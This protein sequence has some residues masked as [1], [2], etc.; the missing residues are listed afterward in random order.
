MKKFSLHYITYQTFP[1]STANSLQTI[2]NIKYLL[3]NNIEVS[4]FFPLRDSNSNS[5]IDSINE[6]YNTDLNFEITGLKHNYPF[7]KT[8]YLE[9]ILFHA[10]HFLWAKKNVKYILKNFQES[11][12]YMTR[13]DW[14][15]FF[16]IL[17]RKKVVFECHQTSKLRTII[18]FFLK[19]KSNAKIVF[20]NPYLYEKYGKNLKRRNC[21]ILQNGV[22]LDEIDSKLKYKK[23]QIIFAGNIERFKSSRGID[24]LINAFL[25]SKI[26]AEYKLIIVG[27]PDSAVEK[28][29]EEYINSETLK[30]LEILGYLNHKKTLKILAESQI[31]VLI[32]TS[33]NLHSKFYTSPLKYFEYLA[34]KLK[35]I[36]VDLPSHRVLKY[37]EEI[38]YFNEG[39]EDQLISILNNIDKLKENN[40]TNLNEITL[41]FR[42]KE[43]IKFI[44]N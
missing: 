2:K 20:L 41:D 16:L 23:K 40:I 42:I 21:I 3:R 38:K 22:D 33:N 25:K 24:L 35:I 17:K 32:N 12:Y 11:N 37:N 30:K 27:G 34:F 39:D 26:N 4:L 6:F 44:E 5:S 9:K 43:L 31:G 28:L 7:G 10:S 18:L 8:K 36:A 14:V 1:A 29:K 19:N 15:F 13:S